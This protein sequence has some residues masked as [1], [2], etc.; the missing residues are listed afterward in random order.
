MSRG[1]TLIEL[2]FTATLLGI[3]IV[4][5]FNLLP[6]S[7]MAIRHAEHRIEAT[8]FAESILEVK[9]TGPFSTIEEAPTAPHFMGNDGTMYQ[10]DYLPLYFTGAD[11]K[12]LKGMRVTVTWKE[13][14]SEFSLTRE[15]YV[16]SIKK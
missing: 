1:F 10:Y 13:K 3:I 8:S 14:Q 11:T 12:Y 2:I 6:G 9:R 4:A 5:F 7:L 16:S 15:L